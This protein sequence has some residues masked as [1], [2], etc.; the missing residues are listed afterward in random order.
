MAPSGVS[1]QASK[2]SNHVAQHV[3]HVQPSTRARCLL[4]HSRS[5]RSAWLASV[6]SSSASPRRTRTMDS[7]CSRSSS[8]S[9]SDR[10]R[11]RLGIEPV[12]VPIIHLRFDV[13]H[14]FGYGW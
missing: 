3:R 11:T 4:R 2:A 9:D 8:S 12:L 5:T 13:K 6:G 14:L 7:T 1:L 10:T